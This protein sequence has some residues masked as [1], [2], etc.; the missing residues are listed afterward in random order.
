M[1]DGSRYVAS[2]SFPNPFSSSLGLFNEQTP[3]NL[4]KVGLIIP[5]IPCKNRENK[6][7][8]KKQKKT[9]QITKQSTPN[10]PGN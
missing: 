9:K 10:L 4:P 2:P 7:E 3:R 8:K 6:E 5:F 1:F